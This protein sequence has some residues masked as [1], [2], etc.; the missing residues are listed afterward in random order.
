LQE[1]EI[2]DGKGT[3]FSE[4]PRIEHFIKQRDINQLKKLHTVCFGRVGKPEQ[5]KENLLQF[6]GFDY[7]PENDAYTKKKQTLAK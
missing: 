6:K 3:A 5:V 1:I 7:E 4:C 2:P